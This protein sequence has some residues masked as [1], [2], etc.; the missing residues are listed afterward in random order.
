MGSLMVADEDK[1]AELLLYVGKRTADDPTVGAVKLNKLL[2]FA[3]FAAVRLFGHPI[4]GVEYQRLDNGPAPRRLLPIRQRLVEN[5]SAE[6]RTSPVFGFAQQ[7]LIPLREPDLTAFSREELQIVDE[8]V[9]TLRGKTAVEVSAIS[10]Q[11]A[12]WRMV[13][14]REVIPYEFAVVRPPH[15]TPEIRA[16][17]E[18]LAA[19]FHVG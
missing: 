5:G 9:D 10:H 14:D 16:H 11:E 3:E 2:Y 7:R 19:Q 15:L 8:V 12:G 18:V 6:L 17:A 4:T 1:F 13:G